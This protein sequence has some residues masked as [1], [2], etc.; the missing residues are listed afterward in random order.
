M[1]ITGIQDTD[2]HMLSEFLTCA[3]LHNCAQ[4]NK[5]TKKL[6]DGTLQER[7]KDAF[8]SLPNLEKDHVDDI[9]RIYRINKSDRSIIKRHDLDS[10]RIHYGVVFEWFIQY[11]VKDT[12]CLYTVYP[13]DLNMKFKIK[14]DKDNVL[15]L[16]MRE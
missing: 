7:K 16:F 1:S 3:E 9:K 15:S 4:V 10:I 8:L 5:E 11:I 14:Q 13:N 12:I 6:L 2:Y